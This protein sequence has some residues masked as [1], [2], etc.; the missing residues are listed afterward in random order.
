V[1]E[2]K[3]P[4]WLGNFRRLV[5]HWQRYITMDSAFSYA[6]CLRITLKKFGRRFESMPALSPQVK[7]RTTRWSWCGN[8]GLYVQPESNLRLQR[9]ETW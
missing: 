1:Q 6:P 7:D 9:S 5:V 4:A 3:T 2:E 8:N